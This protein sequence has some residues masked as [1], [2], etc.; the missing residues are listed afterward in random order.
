[1]NDTQVLD[2]IKEYMV[3]ALTA[4]VFLFVLYMNVIL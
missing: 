4:A 1:M 2:I 3:G